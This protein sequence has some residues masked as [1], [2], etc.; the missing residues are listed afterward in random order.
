LQMRSI[1]LSLA[2]TLLAGFQPWT[3]SGTPLLASGSDSGGLSFPAC[4]PGSSVMCRRYLTP[5]LLLRAPVR[6]KITTSSTAD[7]CVIGAIEARTE[8]L[9]GPHRDSSEETWVYRASNGPVRG[10]TRTNRYTR[11]CFASGA[12]LVWDRLTSAPRNALTHPGLELSSFPPGRPLQV[13]V[14]HFYRHP[15][16]A[17]PPPPPGVIASAGSAPGQPATGV[18]ALRWRELDMEL[19]L[20]TP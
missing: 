2:K 18:S 16:L 5:S 13:G 20:R 4:F 14:H 12:W 15:Q 17:R 10:R 11:P 9:S 19:P 6:L 7:R 8:P 1:P 3:S